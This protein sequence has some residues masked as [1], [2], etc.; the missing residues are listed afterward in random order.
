MRV[1]L[2]GSNDRKLLDIVQ[3]FAGSQKREL[4][5]FSLL[6]ATEPANRTFLYRSLEMIKNQGD[7][8]IIFIERFD[9][10]I[11]QTDQ[12]LLDDILADFAQCR[13]TFIY[14]APKSLSIPAKYQRI[15]HQI[16]PEIFSLDA[17]TGKVLD[18][19]KSFF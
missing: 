11:V 3:R 8:W 16:I 19:L 7:N 13:S 17:T 10:V 18:R 15:F 2:C 1:L 5:E 9:I 6:K 12:E 14:T 4:V